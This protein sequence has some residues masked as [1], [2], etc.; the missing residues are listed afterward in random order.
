MI[1]R[2]PLP[3]ALLQLLAVAAPAQV[4]LDETPVPG[5]LYAR[6]LA[7]GAAL[8]P[9][10]GT[11][12]APGGERI[13][14]TVTRDGAPWALDEAPL[15]YSGGAAPF[16]LSATIEAGLHDYRFELLLESNGLFHSLGAVEQ[17]VCGDA[18]L[19]QGQSNAV[20]SDYHLEG[21]ANTSRSRWIR[22]FGS[23]SI[24]PGTAGAD[25][26]WR[27]ADGEGGNGPGTIG[28]WGLRMGEI[29]VARTGVPVA[30]LN[31]AVG[32]TRIEAHQRDPNDPENLATI[33]GRLLYRARRAGLDL[34]VRALLWHQG[35]SNGG[36]D[37]WFYH[38]QFR[39]LRDDWLRDFT[40]LERIYVFQIRRG[41]LVSGTKI[42]EVQREFPDRFPEVVALP[43]AGIAGHD[44]CHFYARGY[45]TMGEWA[46][47]RVLAD[48]HGLVL[49]REAA[50]PNVLSARF[51]SPAADE[52]EVLFRDPNQVLRLDPGIED[53]LRLP[54]YPETVVSVS[55][56]R[57]RLLLQLSAPS[58]ATDLTYIGNEGDGPWILNRYGA[59]AFTFHIPIA[60]S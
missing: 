45:R 52:I 31:G 44:G 11:V 17:V 37:P 54:G 25:L 55:A 49:P 28:G 48:L 51:T 57:G 27:V 32:G 29:V 42:R 9:V 18:Y 7:T 26:A 14:L 3:F 41:C 36:S 20:A 23:A 59:G 24:D 39:R 43:T 15:S 4:T 56:A 50:P 8:V 13:H 2:F 38:D 22:S 19:I 30:L 10:S 53:R 58:L 40:G 1:Q 21:V 12:T 5:R 46:A 33:Y 6:E 35:E 34:Q 16:A 47:V 60:R